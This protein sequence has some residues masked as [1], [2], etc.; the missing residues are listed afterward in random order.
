MDP[1]LSLSPDDLTEREVALASGWF[2][3]STEIRRRAD[4]WYENLGFPAGSASAGTLHPWTEFLAEQS[5]LAQSTD[6]DHTEI[7]DLR[8]P[9][10]LERL[11]SGVAGQH[12]PHP[13]EFHAEVERRFGRPVELDLATED[14]F[15]VQ[16]AVDTLLLDLPVAGPDALSFVRIF[17][18]TDDTELVGITWTDLLGL[19][20]MA[21]RELADRFSASDSL[22]HE[23]LHSK[24]AT[25]DRGLTTPFL[26]EPDTL[27]RITIPWRAAQPAH[28][29]W[30]TLRAFDAYYV[31][32]HLTILWGAHLLQTTPCRAAD[33]LRAMALDRLQRVCFRAEY[34]SNQLRHARFAHL[35]EDRIQLTEWLDCIRLPAFGLSGPGREA[36]ATPAITVG[37]QPAPTGPSPE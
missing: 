33:G 35:D 37:G 24:M 28:A 8:I 4:A 26:D 22:F 23:A 36:L 32:A 2:G 10:I 7:L 21:R 12:Y 3:D 16:N 5:A 14:A 6:Q 18:V 9:P 13:Q 25:I 34:L 30:S 29:S 1:M 31:Y 27:T 19:L 11:T 17:A 15:A 20:V